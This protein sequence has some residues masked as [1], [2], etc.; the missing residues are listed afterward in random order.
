MPGCGLLV[1]METNLLDARLLPYEADTVS[2]SLWR[3]LALRHPTHQA[4]LV[5]GVKIASSHTSGK[6]LWWG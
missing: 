3:G 5:A 1:S 4:K 2:S 6:S